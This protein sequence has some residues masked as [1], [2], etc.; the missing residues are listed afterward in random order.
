MAHQDS[1]KCPA[2][3]ASRPP[4]R[5]RIFPVWA[6]RP[7]YAR[8]QNISR[9]SGH[10]GAVPE[11][12]RTVLARWNADGTLDTTFSEDGIVE[13]DLATGRQEASLGVAELADGDVVVAVNAVDEDTGQSVYLLRFDN[14]GAQ[15]AGWG[16]EQGKVEIVFGWPNANNAAFKGEEGKKPADSSWSIKVDNST[17]TETIVMA[18]FGSAAEGADRNDNDRFVLRLIAA[19]GSNDPSFNGGK[20]FTYHSAA[21]FA[22]GGRNALVEAD[23]AILSAG[24]TNFG[25]GLGNHVILLRLLPDG[26]LD[27]AFGNFIEPASTGEAIGISA[28]PGV[29]IFNPFLVDGGVAE[30]YAVAKAADGSYITTGYGE[31]TAEGGESS[32]GYESSQGPDVVSFKVTATGLDTA[33]G[34]GGTQAIQSEGK[35]QP[36]AEDRGRNLVGLAD[37]RTVHV[38]RFGG[39]AA[40]YVLNADG[41][42]DETQGDHGV[43]KLGH[44]TIDAQ[45]FG[46]AL[47]ADGKHIAVTTNANAVG[48][49]LVILEVN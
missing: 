38:G 30:G 23:G 29:A 12:T 42:L 32:L 8:R 7:Q 3:Y 41:Q 21:A 47:S 40:V 18:G 39:N 14:T 19:D 31:A 45:F 43:I 20:P 1:P 11:E 25:D 37:G 16:D 44:P 27:P 15:K 10:A 13:V 49:R 34:N 6:R 46:A 26:T 35:G 22:D 48:A 9:T 5:S 33:Y 28:Q 4:P 24:Y 17:G 36:T 2:P